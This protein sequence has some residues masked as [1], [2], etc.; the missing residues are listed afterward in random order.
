MHVRDRV[1]RSITPAFDGSIE[2]FQRFFAPV[3]ASVRN[4]QTKPRPSSE[5][6]RLFE[7]RNR[8]VEAPHLAV[9]RCK[10]WLA[11][12]G[13]CRI[14]LERAFSGRDR[15]IVKPEI[16][17]ELAGEVTYPKRSR[18]DLR[19]ALQVRQRFVAIASSGV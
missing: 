14:K 17:V 13:K 8:F 10:R 6:S 7:E 15:F 9:Q 4:R 5:L 12:M 18:I 19:C 2:S 1:S 16:T 11:I 3:H